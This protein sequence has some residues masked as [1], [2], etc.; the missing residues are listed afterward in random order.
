MAPFTASLAVIMAFQR[1]T[2]NN[3]RTKCGDYGRILRKA[4]ATTYYRWPT[5]LA[6]HKAA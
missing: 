1:R 4:P 2:V 6:E 5:V 3:H